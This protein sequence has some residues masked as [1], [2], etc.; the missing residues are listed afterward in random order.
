M[1]RILFKDQRLGLLAARLLVTLLCLTA[2]RIAAQPAVSS[3]PQESLLK[4]IQAEDERRWGSDLKELLSNKNAAI[5]SRSALA[6]GRIGDE[7]AVPPLVE[8]L[9]KDTD[10]DV[11]ESAI[12]SL[13]EIESPLGADALIA[14]LKKSTEPA[15][16][17]ARAVEALGKIAGSLGN[18]Q[19]QRRQELNVVI[20]DT[21]KAEAARG[22]AADNETVLL[23]LTAALRSRVTNA[24]PTIAEFLSQSSPRVRA[25]AANALARLR[26]KDGAA[27][28]QDLLA[29]DSDPIVR[30]NAARALGAAENRDA[31]DALLDHAI[32]DSDL[33]VRVSAIRAL[34][35]LKD[36]RAAQSLLK[37]GQ[38]LTA[39]DLKKKPSETNE[40]LEIVS[41]LG[42]ILQGSDNQEAAGWLKQVRDGFANQ[43]PEA[44]IA[45]AR[46][47]PS[48]YLQSIGW[49]ITAYSKGDKTVLDQWRARSSAAQ[50][51]AEIANSPA[52]L[53]NRA[54]LITQGE[55]LVGR[56]LAANDAQIAPNTKSEQAALSLPEILRSFAAFK[57][58]NVSEVLRKHMTFKDVIIRATAADLLGELPPEKTNEQVL[59]E[60]FPLALTDE[61]NDAALS[62]LDSLAKQKTASANEA[63]KKGLESSDH[64]IRRRA[65]ALLKANGAGDFSSRIANVITRN[66]LA[67]YKRAVA[68]FKKTTNANVSTSRGSFVIEFLSENAPLT[69]DNFVRLAQKGY[70]NGQTIPRVVPNFVVQ[71]GDPRGDQN[72]GPGYS[73]RCEINQVPYD[74]AAVG[75]A[76]SGKDTGGSQW[77][78]THSPQP[79]LDGGY[80][81]FGRVVS[82]MDVVDRIVRGDTII[83]VTITEHKTLG[84]TSRNQTQ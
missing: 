71:A 17:R 40:V 57:T 74:R 38:T 23:G 77:F 68:R 50:A 80:T 27:Q 13:G 61:L 14:V 45:F 76:L 79:H 16:A 12:F 48:A 43:A 4:I 59:I 51:L 67:D 15:S 28:L 75:M 26:L 83:S 53:P 31:L 19:E 1:I 6:A 9:S 21:L 66:S 5:R 3:V 44:E 54:A 7:G 78:V 8:L 20:L 33:R 2:N 37:R 52:T 70:F 82:G 25:D 63:I 22:T 72:G 32:K 84:T 73:I 69:V 49:D 29:K 18:D 10:P 65:V 58:Q 42:R 39:V 34:A 24:G 60:S 56:L 41:T 62:I 46:V 30:A 64:L 55:S 36:L 35:G 81:V 47:S 11:R